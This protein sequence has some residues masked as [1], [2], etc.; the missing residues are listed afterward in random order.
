M[1]FLTCILIF[2]IITFLW[3]TREQPA[4]SPPPE[5]SVTVLVIAGITMD[6]LQES[7]HEFQSKHKYYLIP[8]YIVC[9]KCKDQQKE[10]FKVLHESMV[11]LNI[12]KPSGDTMEKSYYEQSIEHYDLNEPLRF[13]TRLLSQKPANTAT[14]LIPHQFYGIDSYFQPDVS[15]HVYDIIRGDVSSTKMWKPPQ[16]RFHIYST[17]NLDLWPAKMYIENEILPGAE[18]FE[19]LQNVV[20]SYSPKYNASDYRSSDD[21]SSVTFTLKPDFLTGL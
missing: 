4:V 18:H 6:T 19:M 8:D 21:I 17:Q 5:G 7:L 16:N 9:H 10:Q 2:I 13:S 11:L 20:L 15:V 12:L 14:N 1:I 3:I